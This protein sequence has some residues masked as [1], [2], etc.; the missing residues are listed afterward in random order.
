MGSDSPG[1]IYRTRDWMVPRIRASDTIWRLDSTRSVLVLAIMCSTRIRISRW[2]ACSG[3]TRLHAQ[4]S[5]WELD[6]MWRREFG[7]VQI[8]SG[9]VL[10]SWNGKGM[11]NG[12]KWRGLNCYEA[13]SDE[14]ANKCP[15]NDATGPCVNLVRSQLLSSPSPGINWSVYHFIFFGDIILYP[16]FEVRTKKFVEFLSIDFQ[17]LRAVPGLSYTNSLLPM[18]IA[19]RWRNCTESYSYTHSPDWNMPGTG[20][21]W[22]KNCSLKIR[23]AYESNKVWGRRR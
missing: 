5:W 20:S 2:T 12:R 6:R 3:C 18:Q 8:D 11:W 23:R 13:I 10:D 21:L 7:C 1:N 9:C 19:G 17:M 4:R 14:G 16:L 15:F 22:Y